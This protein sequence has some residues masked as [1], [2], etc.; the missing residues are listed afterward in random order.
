MRYWACPGGQRKFIKL[1]GIMPHVSLVI[2]AD[3]NEQSLQL[4]KELI[5]IHKPQFNI[6]LW[7]KA[8]GTRRSA[9]TRE[10]MSMWQ[11]GLKRGVN[12]NFLA[13]A[14]KAHTGKPLSSEHKTKLSA[15]LLGKNV[16]KVRT[17]EHKAAISAKLKGRKLSSEICNKRKG[18]T[19]WNK[20]LP[21]TEKHRA[22]LR[23]ACARRLSH[24]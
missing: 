15:A 11:R 18:R 5:A 23:A 8:N 10:K 2:T 21:A 9:K 6:A 13:A 3:T 1:Y 12:Q 14:I 4:E 24:A 7:G 19:P 17:P 16:G 22:A 20:G